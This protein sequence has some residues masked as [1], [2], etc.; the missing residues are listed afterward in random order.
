[1]G[2]HKLIV[3]G[4]VSWMN[5]KEISKAVTEEVAKRQLL[6]HQGKLKSDKDRNKTWWR[7]AVSRAINK[8]M[9]NREMDVDSNAM[10]V[11]PGILMIQRE[12]KKEVLYMDSHGNYLDEISG[13][14]LSKE[15]VRKARLEEFKEFVKRK[16]LDVVPVQECW[17]VTSKAP[18]K[19]R[20]LDMNKGDE[21][22]KD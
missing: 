8:E 14:L 4:Q 11:S 13:K 16:V 21:K 3:E 22:D 17:E 9:D 15:L 5:S 18:I 6:L 1:M 10:E 20:W 19:V 2:A 7:R 12:D